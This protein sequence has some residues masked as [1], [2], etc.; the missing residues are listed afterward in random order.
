MKLF[1]SVIYLN[2]LAVT[3]RKQ[4]GKQQTVSSRPSF[5]RFSGDSHR[6]DFRVNSYLVLLKILRFYTNFASLRSSMI[7]AY[8][9]CISTSRRYW[10][11]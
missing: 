3:A 4:S 5:H 1:P 6:T 11:Y 2:P 8:I 7:K 10:F 9:R